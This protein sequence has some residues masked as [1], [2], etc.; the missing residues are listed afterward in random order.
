M[1]SIAYNALRF[2]LAVTFIW[3]GVLIVLDP[4]AWGAFLKPW[5]VD[6]L[7]LPLITFV[8]AT[9]ILDIVIGGFLLFNF[10]PSFAA[11][12]GAIHL[13][14]ILVTTGIDAVTVRDIGLLGAAIALSIESFRRR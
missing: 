9:G 12:I 10:F 5:A 6:L 4:V 1:S 2:G 11:A 7:P 14:G 8:M 3:I 13:A